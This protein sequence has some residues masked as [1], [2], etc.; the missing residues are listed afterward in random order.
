MTYRQHRE[1][2]CRSTVISSPQRNYQKTTLYVKCDRQRDRQTDVCTY[3]GNS[4]QVKHFTAVTPSV[5][6]AVLRLTLV[7]T[8]ADT[9]TDLL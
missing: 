9:V 6:V 2:N 7:Y 8:D 1:E 3:C 4:E 5:S